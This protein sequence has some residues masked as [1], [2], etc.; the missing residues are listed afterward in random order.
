MMG[1]RVEGRFVL[2]VVAMTR[3]TCFRR[4]RLLGRNLIT[5]FQCVNTFAKIF[6]GLVGR[7][8]HHGCVRHPRRQSREQ[9]RFLRDTESVL[10]NSAFHALFLHGADRRAQRC[11]GE[12][13]C[14]ACTT[15]TGRGINGR[16]A[17]VAKARSFSRRTSPNARICAN[18]FARR[19]P[20]SRLRRKRGAHRRA[21]RG[22]SGGGSAHRR[23]HG[24]RLGVRP[25]ITPATIERNV[26]NTTASAARC[27]HASPGQRTPVCGRAARAMARNGYPRKQ[28]G[29]T[30]R[31]VDGQSLGDRRISDPRPRAALRN[32]RVPAGR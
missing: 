28:T 6:S 26:P 31:P 32:R 15:D 11:H 2:L 30:G 22:L 13:R 4:K 23:R 18:F 29:R 12:G 14:D 25:G 21:R 24:F 17:G 9:V 7:P 10:K 3:L 27:R 20:P 16:T 5:L 8:V 19:T 1:A